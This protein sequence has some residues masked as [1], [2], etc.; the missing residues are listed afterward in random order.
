MAVSKRYVKWVNLLLGT[1]FLLPVLVALIVYKGGASSFSTMNKGTLVSPM[2]VTNNMGFRA[3]DA[4]P[5]SFDKKWHVLY[6]VSKCDK[7][8]EKVLD[9]ILRVRLALGRDMARTYAVLAT[10]AKVSHRL[11][12]TMKSV[13]Q[14]DT[15][16]FLLP[17]EALG[18]GYIFIVDP[19]GNVM[20]RYDG[21][22]P[23][24]HIHGDLTRLLKVSKIG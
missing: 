17:N 11:L 6:H 3:Y 5:V 20:M 2:L 1:L 4:K 18:L 22:V 7:A 8:C 23:P 9:K 16:A 21:N 10:Q 14:L 12:E 19:L 15:H 13:K 24:K